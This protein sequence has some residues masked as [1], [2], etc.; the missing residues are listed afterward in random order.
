MSELPSDRLQESFPLTY[1]DFDFFGLFT[2]K[3]YRKDLKRYAVMFTCSCGVQC[4]CRAMHIK[5]VYSLETESFILLLR[6]FIGRPANIRL[7]RYNSWTNFVCIIN[8]LQK[9]FQE[10][11]KYHSICK[12]TELIG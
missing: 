5:V 1:C 2:V 3:N 11:I 9:P 8:E 7:V 4:R 10:I 6:K 12:H